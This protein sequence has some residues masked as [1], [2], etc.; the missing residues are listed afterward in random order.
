MFITKK[1]ISRRTVLRG[2]GAAVAL[3]LLE[4]M[5]PAATAMSQTAAVPRSRFIGIEVAHGSAVSTEYGTD[6]LL[7]NMEKEGTELEFTP[8]SILTPLASLRDYV[9]VVTMLDSHQADPFTPAEVGADHFRT[10]AVF[11]TAAHPKQTQGSDVF[12]GPSIDQIYAQK[13]GQDTPLPSI[14]LCT[15]NVSMSG[16]SMFNY[17]SVYMDT[18]S[19]SSSTT[20]L[21]MTY[22]P[23]VAFEELF[24][25]GGSPE[26]RAARRK[27]NRSILDVISH[28]VAMI[29][30]ELNTK[31]R[32]RLND[33]LDNVREIERRIQKVEEYNSRAGNRAEPTAPVGV[34]DVWE[35]HVKLLIELQV[36]AFAGEVTRVSTLKLSKEASNRVFPE[37]GTTT[38]FHSASH[39]GETA[40][41]IE[42]L[43]KIN[44]YHVN[45]VSYFADRLKK[46]PDGDGNLLD[47]SLI[48]YGAAMGNSNTHGHKRV[49]FVLVGHA[50][51]TVKGNMHLRCKD[52]TPQ[53]NGLL[54]VLHKLGVEEDHIG[55]ST[56]TLSI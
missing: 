2:M 24:G 42:E 50:S 49:P 52:E 11:L 55:D 28:D 37:S 43:A 48:L 10:A 35:D 8:K 56:G 45:L 20:P 1:H 13:F 40:T 41:G 19:W 46:T 12:N 30:K 25:T 39:H 31:D 27:A 33:Y 16:V 15:E 51:G 23:R 36:L 4:S 3:P 5:I 22:N 32:S 26:D 54:T 53:A 9:T 44:R 17:S 47:H 21:T 29:S 38:P 7:V 6:N 18:I 34:P 14:Q